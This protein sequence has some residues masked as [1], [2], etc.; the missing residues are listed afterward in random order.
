MHTGKCETTET[1]DCS[2]R[3]EADQSEEQRLRPGLPELGDQQFSDSI[4][5]LLQSLFVVLEGDTVSV[6][7]L[8]NLKSLLASQ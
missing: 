1:L 6:V 3:L 8:E 7:P 5:P 4:L 2:C